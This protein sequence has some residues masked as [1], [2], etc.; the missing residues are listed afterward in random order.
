MTSQLYSYRWEVAFKVFWALY[1]WS[2]HTFTGFVLQRDRAKKK[3]QTN[4]QNHRDFG[5][6]ESCLGGIL[7]VYVYSLQS[8]HIPL[9][10]I[11]RVHSRWA[12]YDLLG[13]FSPSPLSADNRGRNGWQ[14]NAL[15]LGHCWEAATALSLHAAWQSGFR[16]RWPLWIKGKGAARL[17]LQGREELLYFV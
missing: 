13:I 1:F 7:L 10:S 9:E 4:P 14:G 15:L 3:I 6:M 12:W 8:L 2:P 11:Y 17:M 5:T 16:A